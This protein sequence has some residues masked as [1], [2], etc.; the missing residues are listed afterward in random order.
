MGFIA[1]ALFGT[2]TK[3]NLGFMGTFLMMGLFMVIGASL[4]NIFLHSPM[5]STFT[6]WVGI[7]VFSGLTAYDSQ[8]IRQES[9][10]ISASSGFNQEMMGKYMI[11]HALTM[12]L[13]FINLFISLLS[14]FGNRRE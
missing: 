11:L 8:R 3:K 10:A 1:L 2:F 4:V 5:L 13:N 12:Y 14:I 9:Y 6:G 7:L